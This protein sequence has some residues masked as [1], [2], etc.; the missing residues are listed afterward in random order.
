MKHG[1]SY[2]H[3]KTKNKNIGLVNLSHSA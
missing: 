1:R 2:L 3:K